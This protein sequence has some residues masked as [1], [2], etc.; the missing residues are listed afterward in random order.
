MNDEYTMYHII[1]CMF[2]SIVM[3]KILTLLVLDED[4]ASTQC[5]EQAFG[6]C[7]AWLDI[8]HTGS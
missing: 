7:V 2:Q 5:S 6:F 4:W 8:I 3:Q 1:G